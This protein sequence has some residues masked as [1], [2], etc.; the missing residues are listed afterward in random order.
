MR[1]IVEFR[2]FNLY[3]VIGQYYC[4][5]K[6]QMEKTCMRVRLGGYVWNAGHG[7]RKLEAV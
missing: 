2:R 7:T 1:I 5:S 6:D 3:L 4:P